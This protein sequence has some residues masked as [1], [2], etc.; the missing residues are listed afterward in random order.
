M[1]NYNFTVYA[2]VL[3]YI[4]VAVPCYKSDISLSVGRLWPYTALEIIVSGYA[5]DYYLAGGITYLQTGRYP[6]RIAGMYAPYLLVSIT[7][8]EKKLL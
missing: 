5:L 3:L 1:I 2:I 7:Y 8:K 6:L 4:F